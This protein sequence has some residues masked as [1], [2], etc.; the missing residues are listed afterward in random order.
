MP[1]LRG[2]AYRLELFLFVDFLGVELGSGVIHFGLDRPYA[3]GTFNGALDE[4]AVLRVACLAVAQ[5]LLLWT[6]PLEAKPFTHFRGIFVRTEDVIG[7]L[8]VLQLH[9]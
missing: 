5:L 7:L 2:L 6:Q 3:E 4:T 9:L 1:D 8:V